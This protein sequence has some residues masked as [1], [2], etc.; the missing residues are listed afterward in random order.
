MTSTE[1]T[2]PSLARLDDRP[3]KI[4]FRQVLLS[5][6]PNLTLMEGNRERD[7]LIAETQLYSYI[8]NRT[9]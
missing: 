3:S 2:Y 6:R 5:T 7:P 1:L 4:T 8:S 9:H